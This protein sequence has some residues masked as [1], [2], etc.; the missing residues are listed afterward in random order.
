[1]T[2]SFAPR[3]CIWI[4]L[5][6]GVLSICACSQVKREVSA[7]N[8]ASASKPMPWVPPDP[9]KIAAGPVGDSI[10]QGRFIF[11]ETPKH[12]TPYV[13][14]KLSCNDC[15]IKGGTVAYASPMVGLPGIFPMF[16]NRANRVI[17]LEDRI[18]ECFTRSENG[19]P[20]LYNSREM[21]ALI[22]YI[23]WLSIG[24]VDGKGFPGRGFVR[25]P[26]LEGNEAN[27]ERIYGAQCASCH[28][29]DGAGKPTILPALW[30]PDSYND[31]AGMNQVG[32]M[33]AFVQRNMPQNRPGTLSAQDA[34]DVSAFIKTKP[35]PKFNPEY[36]NF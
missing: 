10:R 20:L 19:H 23:H 9:A 17:S 8:K 15:H 2:S 32:Q 4:A 24:Q 21:I 28:G 7:E 5:S 22:S 35:R 25:L 29:A 30:G 1:M 36:G 18:Q 3:L 31:G 33:A 26:E 16:N 12:A 14:N 6:C 11:T 13:G 34:Y 27:G